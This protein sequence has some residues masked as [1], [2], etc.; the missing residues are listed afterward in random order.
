M[1][2]LR[3]IKAQVKKLTYISEETLKIPGLCTHHW[4]SGNLRNGREPYFPW[5]LHKRGWGHF[6]FLKNTR[7]NVYQMHWI[8]YVLPTNT[9]LEWHGMKK[10][11]FFKSEE[12]Y[13]VKL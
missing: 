10:P 2:N 4:V 6:E 12:K 11:L 8:L 9:D 7:V 13:L 3:I 1:H 5:G